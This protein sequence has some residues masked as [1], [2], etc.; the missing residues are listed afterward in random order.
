MGWTG[1]H[2]P[3]FFPL[4]KLTKTI[5]DFA[6]NTLGA[7]LVG[8][9]SA[10]DSQFARAPQGHHPTDYVPGAKSV[11]V[12][13]IRQLKEI[14][15]ATPNEIH[16]KQYDLLNIWLEQSCYRMARKLKEMKF[17]AMNMPET[18]PYP[19]FLAM[20]AM[21]APR[22]S[23]VFCHIHAA[24]A[25]GLGKRGKVG[26][27]LMPQ[28]GPLQRWTS[29]ITTAELVPDPRLKKEVCLDFIK[30]GSCD[31][32][33]KGCINGSLRAWPEEGGIQMYKCAA[34]GLKATQGIVCAN[35]IAACPLGK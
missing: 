2:L 13:G 12:I 25:A 24:V 11:V 7:D 31:K 1:A 22:F 9:A 35:C 34:T 27:V 28:F 20:K 26:V 33:V 3:R 29:V 18:D 6:L 32:C 4:S 8:V 16:S 10:T 23:P 30:P 17:S 19:K 21:G 15:D 14:I 5:K